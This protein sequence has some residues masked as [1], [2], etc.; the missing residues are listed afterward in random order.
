GDSLWSIAAQVYGDGRLYTKIVQANID[1]FITLIDNPSL[2]R[3]DWSLII[4]K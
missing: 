4:P 2:I 3:V 1:E